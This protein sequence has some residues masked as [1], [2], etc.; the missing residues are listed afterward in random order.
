MQGLHVW[1]VFLDQQVVAGK[2][3]KGSSFFSL[4]LLLSAPHT[5]MGTCWTLPKVS[6]KL[7]ILWIL[8]LAQAFERAHRIVKRCEDN[9]YPTFS[10]IATWGVSVNPFFKS[11][12]MLIKKRLISFFL[13]SFHEFGLPSSLRPVRVER[14]IWNVWCL[15]RRH[16]GWHPAHCTP[17]CIAD[18]WQ[19][20]ARHSRPQKQHR[21]TMSDA[22]GM[23][24]SVSAG[25]PA[26]ILC[27]LKDEFACACFQACTIGSQFFFNLSLI[28]AWAQKLLSRE[29]M[30]SCVWPILLPLDCNVCRQMCSHHSFRTVLE[31]RV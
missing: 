31:I 8:A 5:Q 16:F 17:V 28:A 10:F 13:F 9:N 26:H 23:E 27:F 14:T 2:L 4:S 29:V 11:Y 1:P 30:V 25:C 6:A 18:R 12:F 3:L 20:P 21:P 22:L 7:H 15:E 24:I 19:L